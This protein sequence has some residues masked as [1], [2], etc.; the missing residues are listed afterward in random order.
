MINDDPLTARINKL[1]QHGLVDMHFD[2]LMDLFEK[3][4]RQNVISTDYL[5]NLQSGDVGVLGVAIYVNN[6]YLPE[7]GLRVAL[8]Q[9]ARLYTELDD[10]DHLAVCRSYADI[11]QARQAGRIALLITMEGVEPLG[12]GIN[13]LRVFYELGLRSIGLTH[14][15][16]NEAG[17][18]GVFAPSGSSPAGLTAFGQEIVR[19]CEQLGI[20]LDLAHLNPAGFEEV[21]AMTTRPPIISHTNP[22]RFFDIERNSSDEQIKMVSKRG[23]VVGLGVTLLTADKEKF[24]L[25]HFVDQIEYVV[26]LTGI[27]SVGLGFDFFK[28]IYDTMSPEDTAGFPDIY[29]MPDFVDHSH[30]R[31]LTRKLI[32]RGFA[33]NE[34]EKILYGN[35]M[36]IFKAWL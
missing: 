26:K 15:R 20:I 4:N 9:I 7:M 25:D 11:L 27:D 32:Q 21:M 36:R 1:H 5:P 19:Q 33:D 30:S 22:R 34:I 28:F 2:M 17:S 12:S 23:G 10:L 24:H 3:R 18:G 16:R 14:A 8:N 6:Q 35:F 13:L 31:N 29:F